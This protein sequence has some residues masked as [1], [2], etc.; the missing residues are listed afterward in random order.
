MMVES[1]LIEANRD[2]LGGTPV[3]AGTRVPVQILFDYLQADHRLDDF[4]GDFPTVSREQATSLL[5]AL[6]LILL[7]RIYERVA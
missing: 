6:K 7:S 3:F 5:E 2:V 1:K 4:L